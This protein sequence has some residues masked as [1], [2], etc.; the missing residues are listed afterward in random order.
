MGVSGRGDAVDPETKTANHNKA[1]AGSEGNLGQ[2][3]SAEPTSPLRRLLWAEPPKGVD[4][5]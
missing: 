2:A 3:I 4:R 5:W 1:R